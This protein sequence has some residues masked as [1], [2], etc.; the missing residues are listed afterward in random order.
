MRL[1]ADI[2]NKEIGLTRLMI[3]DSGESV[4]LFG[5]KTIEDSSADWD[6][7]YETIHDAIE[8]CYQEYN[9]KETDW[10]K[11]E[12]PLENCQH[13]WIKPVRIKGRDIGKP[14]WGNLQKLEAGKWIDIE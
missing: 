1:I 11:I 12:D 8:S 2:N 3:Y 14:E 10:K 5:Y 7:W 13:D 4:Y 6:E 9:V